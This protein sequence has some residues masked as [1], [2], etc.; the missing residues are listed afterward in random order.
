MRTRAFA[1]VAVAAAGCASFSHVSA[2]PLVASQPSAEV[3]ALV[4]AFYGDARGDLP[5]FLARAEEVIARHPGDGR[6]HEVAAYAALLLG[7]SAAV[8]RHFVAAA[9]DLRSDATALYLWEMGSGGLTPHEADSLRALLGGLSSAL[10]RVDSRRNLVPH[11]SRPSLT[12]SLRAEDGDIRDTIET[13]RSER[14]VPR[15]ASGHARGSH[16]GIVAARVEAPPPSNE[17]MALPAASKIYRFR[18]SPEISYPPNAVA[19]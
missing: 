17:G 1:L 13:A 2:P 4:A 16:S 12:K 11:F 9:A 18:Y 15:R 8:T 3:D 14:S 10:V 6:A 7:D 5:H 19:A